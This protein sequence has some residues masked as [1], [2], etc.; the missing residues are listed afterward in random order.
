VLYRYIRR[1]SPSIQPKK[2]RMVV[3]NAS[4]H[5]CK[6]SVAHLHNV[7]DGEHNCAHIKVTHGSGEAQT[8]WPHPQGP[9]PLCGWP[10][11]RPRACAVI[12]Y[13]V[14]ETSPQKA[15]APSTLSQEPTSAGSHVSRAASP[16]PSS[17]FKLR[18]T[19][20][21]TK[22]CSHCQ[23]LQAT[24]LKL[25]TCNVSCTASVHELERMQHLRR[26]W[27]R[28]GP[29]C[30]LIGGV[31]AGVLPR[32]DPHSAARCP[33]QCPAPR[34]NPPGPLLSTASR[35]ARVPQP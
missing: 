13:P 27:G 4:M 5:R 21:D 32:G 17:R 2:T 35:T 3:S 25:W 31:P 16:Q 33:R 29:R 7:G 34:A 9:P 26:R 12:H 28:R 30:P 24:Q 19:C 10:T 14:R 23:H 8:P 15:L 20:R 11:R 1:V 18:C 22:M 6:D